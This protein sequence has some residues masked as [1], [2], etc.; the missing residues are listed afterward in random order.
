MP[1]AWLVLPM[2][3]TPALSVVPPVKVLLA[4]GAST[5]VPGPFGDA[6]AIADDAVADDAVHRQRALIDHEIGIARVDRPGQRDGPRQRV[7][8]VEAFNGAAD[9][10]AVIGSASLKPPASWRLAP[11]AMLAACRS[12]PLDC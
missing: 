12:R 11:L 6:Q 2:V 7:A 8:A 3:K 9:S 1:I 4:V 10:E 5:N